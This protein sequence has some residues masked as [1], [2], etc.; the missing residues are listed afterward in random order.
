VRSD[1]TLESYFHTLSAS[2]RLQFR[3][4]LNK[5]RGAAYPLLGLVHE[6]VTADEKEAGARMALNLGHSLGHAVEAAGGYRDLR[7]GEAVAFG[8]RA[9]CRLGVTTGVTPPDRAARVERLLDLLELGRGTL[10][11]PLDVVLGHLGADKKH[12]A[13]RLRWVLPTA[14]GHSVREDVAD[15][16]V[17][18]VAAGLL[19][20]AAVGGAA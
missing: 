3:T 10:P 14:T 12:R 2:E 8:L 20:P 15:T 19:A 16:L 1:Q 5:L 6:V 4:M 17:R 13:G 11:Y 18:D 7:H 9:A